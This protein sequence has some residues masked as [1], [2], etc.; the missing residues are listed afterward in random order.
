MLE[1]RRNIIYIKKIYEFPDFFPSE[2]CKKHM[3]DQK[4]LFADVLQKNFAHRKTP[5]SEPLFIQSSRSCNVIRIETPTHALTYVD[6]TWLI[7]YDIWFLQFSDM[8]K[9][10]NSLI[11]TVVT[12]PVFY[13]CLSRSPTSATVTNT[14][15]IFL[16]KVNIIGKRKSLNPKASIYT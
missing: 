8:K 5:M 10:D 13:T 2:K 11:L 14:L 9:S 1:F 15:S 6:L 7:L 12:F 3:Y 4:Q 16:N